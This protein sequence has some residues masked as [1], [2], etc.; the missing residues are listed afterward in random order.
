MP[1]ICT[2]GL[3]PGIQAM[4]AERLGNLTY[5]E[6]SLV[7]TAFAGSLTEGYGR[8]DKP[9]EHLMTLLTRDRAWARGEPPP[10][11][12]VSNRFLAME[13]DLEGGRS[14]SALSP[15]KGIRDTWSLLVYD[16]P[17]S[18]MAAPCATLSKDDTDGKDIDCILS[19]Y[20]QPFCL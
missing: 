2:T 11:G 19:L 5:P 15:Q 16:S 8:A 17:N 3:A 14:T 4:T 12:R 6:C 13:I 10:Q 9:I 1:A 7:M 20:K 18:R